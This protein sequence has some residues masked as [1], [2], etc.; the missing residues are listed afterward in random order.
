MENLGS[1]YKNVKAI[2][3]SSTFRIEE[4]AT[5]ENT[6]HLCPE[7]GFTIFPLYTYLAMLA[8]TGFN[9]CNT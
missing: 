8:L 2:L 9:L 6:Y 4:T 5:I 1:F 3:K 7:N